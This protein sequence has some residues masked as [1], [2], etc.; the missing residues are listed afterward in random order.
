[1]VDHHMLGWHCN[2]VHVFWLFVTTCPMG[3]LPDYGFFL[4]G[5]GGES[6]FERSL[7]LGGVEK[8]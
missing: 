5:G 3:S 8:L 1:M 2:V 7:R 4:F 6:G